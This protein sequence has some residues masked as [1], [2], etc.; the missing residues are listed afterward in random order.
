MPMTCKVP[1]CTGLG[2][3]DNRFQKRYLNNGYCGAHYMRLH[4]KLGLRPSIAL[5]KF[6]EDRSNHP[7]YVTYASMKKRCQNKNHKDYKHYGGR[8]INICERWLGVDGFK[9]FLTD[10]GERPKGL[11][12]DRIDNEGNYEPNNC[13]WTT[14]KVQANNRR[15]RQAHG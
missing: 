5:Q 2:A 15:T 10:M 6:G 8:G 3:W 1:G 13:R 14:W 4:R 11:S 7:L 12:L 9:N